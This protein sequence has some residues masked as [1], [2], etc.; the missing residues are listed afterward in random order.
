MF[1]DFADRKF[2]DYTRQLEFTAGRI[3]FSQ[4][5]NSALP[6][7]I[8]SFIEYY[9]PNKNIPINK[10]DFE[11]ILKKAIIFNINYVIKPKN[12]ILKFLFGDVE[13]RPVNFIFH[14]LEYFQ[15]YGYY[16]AQIYD[17]INL[18]SLE[19]VSYSQIEH[20]I[21]EVNSKL[22]EEI[23]G[24]SKDPQRMN[25]VKLLYYFFHDLGE[26]NPINIKIPRKILSVYFQDKGFYDI[27]K[28]VDNFFS[29]EIFIQEAISLMNPETQKAPKRGV[30]EEI[31]EEKVKRIISEAKSLLINRETSILEVEKV[32]QAEEKL[33][34]EIPEI[35]IRLIRE[36]ESKIPEIEKRRLIIDEDIYSDDLMFVSQ[37]KDLVPPVQLTEEEKHQKLL[38]DLFCET[39][40]RK[41]ILK[42]VFSKDEKLFSESAR[43]I[44]SEKN[45]EKAASVIEEIFNKQKV[46]YFSEEAVKFVDIFHNHFVKDYLIPNSSKAS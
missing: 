41:R 20:L 42:T 45:W 44:L 24:Q 9:I 7:F 1:R 13:T 39:T 31:S 18:N 22:L 19:V 26:N 12:T 46:D 8:I 28:R 14:R 3:N 40:F 17:F 5:R 38:D 37:F 35:N 30:D 4:I 11:E 23:T 25:L 21:N 33:P 29:N 32:L 43:L 27:K 6:P 36:N 34:L 10:I 2:D 16:T 15:F